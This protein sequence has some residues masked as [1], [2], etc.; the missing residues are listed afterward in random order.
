MIEV[1]DPA[2]E[3][4]DVPG[5]VPEDVHVPVPEEVHEAP[6]KRQNLKERAQC[7]DC[8]NVVSLYTLRYSH[9]CQKTDIPEETIP[10]IPKEP[11]KPAPKAETV[12]FAQGA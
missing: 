2:L 6:K 10:E 9:K 4:E 3:A 11:K 7:P 8:Q 12:Y 1:E 5:E